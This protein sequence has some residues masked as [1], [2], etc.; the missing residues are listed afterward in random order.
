MRLRLQAATIGAVMLAAPSA[1][2]AGP[3]FSKD[4]APILYKNCVECHRAG[5]MAP[6]S[7]IT[8]D[9]ALQHSF[10]ARELQRLTGRS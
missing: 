4:V 5:A 7:L 1:W 10:D 8:Y 6:M 2:A 9:D 3:T